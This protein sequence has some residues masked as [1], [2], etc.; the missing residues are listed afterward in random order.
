MTDT[1]RLD[2][3]RTSGGVAVEEIDEVSGKVKVKWALPIQTSKL[4]YPL[5]QDV[6]FSAD[7]RYVLVP[8]EFALGGFFRDGDCMRD[9][10][11]KERCI[12][13]V[14]VDLRSHREVTR[15]SVSNDSV[16]QFGWLK[17]RT[18]PAEHHSRL[19]E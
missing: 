3:S 10:E 12:F 14:V 16:E 1:H 11:G 18:H 17:N 13:L 4:T 8:T 9:A 6:R 19:V 2:V 7:R 5:W 15:Q